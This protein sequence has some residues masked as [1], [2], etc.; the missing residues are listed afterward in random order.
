MAYY[1]WVRFAGLTGFSGRGPPT[2]PSSPPARVAPALLLI[3]V[4][5][6]LRLARAAHLAGAGVGIDVAGCLRAAQRA[7]GG[8]ARLDA[9]VGR[10]PVHVGRVGDLFNPGPVPQAGLPREHA[11]PDPAVAPARDGDPDKA[12]DDEHPA[13]RVQV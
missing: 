9:G 6:D 8:Q 13:G 4:L 11:A 5:D 12:D 1:G 3:D 7:R 10:V 2:A